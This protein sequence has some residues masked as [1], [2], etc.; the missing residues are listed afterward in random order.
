[1]VEEIDRRV[2]VLKVHL[3]YHESD[4]VAS[5]Q[6]GVLGRARC[7]ADPGSDDGGGFL[8]AVW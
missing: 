1:L 2:E 8:P 6:R 5:Q 7:T 3:P 4:H